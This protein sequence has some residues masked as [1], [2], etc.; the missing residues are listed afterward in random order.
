[1]RAES[2]DA[3]A[4]IMPHPYVLLGLFELLANFLSIP[5]T[6]NGVNDLFEERIKAPTPAASGQEYDVPEEPP[7]L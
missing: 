1:L 5:R 6:C 2:T 4:L 3:A 7:L